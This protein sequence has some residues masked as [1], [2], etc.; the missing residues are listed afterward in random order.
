M[1]QQCRGLGQ[2]ERHRQGYGTGVFGPWDPITRE[3]MAAILHRYAQFKNYDLSASDSLKMFSDVKSV[4]S[5]ALEAVK[6][7]VG[8]GLIEG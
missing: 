1:V 8:A 3:Q 4:S 6:W 2:Q 5:W 7:A